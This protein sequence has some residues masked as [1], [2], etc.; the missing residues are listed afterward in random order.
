[1]ADYPA[2]S[3]VN[4]ELGKRRYGHVTPFAQ[5]ATMKLDP[6]DLMERLGGQITGSA[7]W[8]DQRRHVFNHK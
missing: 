6:R 3:G 7:M 1:M 8:A 5:A 2:G 4:F